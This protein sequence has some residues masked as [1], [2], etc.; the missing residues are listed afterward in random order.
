VPDGRSALHLDPGRDRSDEFRSFQFCD[1]CW[2]G[3]LVF[4]LGVPWR[5]AYRHEPQLL[6]SPEAL[7]RFIHGQSR[8]ILLVIA[9]F[10]ALY[11][12]SLR[13]MKPR[14]GE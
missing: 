8:E 4:D 9:L 12:L 7:V 10:A 14:G 11:M 3:A 6:T 2:F 1:H 5:Q 13:L